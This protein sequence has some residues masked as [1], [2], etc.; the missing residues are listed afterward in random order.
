MVQQ[1]VDQFFDQSVRTKVLSECPR[2]MIDSLVKQKTR[3][4]DE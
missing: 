4:M 1:S 2:A 3:F